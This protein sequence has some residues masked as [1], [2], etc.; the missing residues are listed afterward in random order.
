MTPTEAKTRLVR[1][2]RR[3]RITIP[4]EF[5]KE[6][7]IGQ[8]SLLHVTLDGGEL[9]LKPVQ[10]TAEPKGSPWLRELYEYYAPARQEAE[11]KGY[12]DEQINAWIDEAVTAVRREQRD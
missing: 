7:G 10:T 8:D 1:S 6:L 11:E 2:L 9:R 3:G 12:T 4:A 5:R